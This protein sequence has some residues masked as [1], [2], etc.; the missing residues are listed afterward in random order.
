MESSAQKVVNPVSRLPLS[1]SLYW[2]APNPSTNPPRLQGEPRTKITQGKFNGTA[3][4]CT[5]L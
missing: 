4:S 1:R 3:P 5:G 2:S